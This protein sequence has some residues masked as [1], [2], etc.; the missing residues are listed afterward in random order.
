MLDML[1]DADWN[2]DEADRR[3]VLAAL[4]YLCDP[5]DVIPDEIPRDRSARRWVMIEPCFASCATSSM[6]M[7]TFVPSATSCRRRG[8][9]CVPGTR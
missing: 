9:A 6:P 2:M 8:S 7:R 1:S 3:P 5:E 4:A